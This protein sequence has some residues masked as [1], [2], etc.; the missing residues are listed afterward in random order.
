MIGLAFLFL[1]VLALAVWSWY[2]WHVSLFVGLGVL[3]VLIA[4]VA[5]NAYY[6]A[7]C[8][9]LNCPPAGSILAV[10]AV[11]AEG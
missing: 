9:V 5:G 8:S 1:G 6:P 4:L 3:V 2:R 11:P 7:H 10:F